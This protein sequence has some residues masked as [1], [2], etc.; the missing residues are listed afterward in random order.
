MTIQYLI[1]IKYL[2]MLL[3]FLVFSLPP[4]K[5]YNSPTQFILTYAIEISTGRKLFRRPLFGVN[6]LQNRKYDY[7]K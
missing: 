7:E 5:S 6:L 1:Q 2:H 4:K 3:Y